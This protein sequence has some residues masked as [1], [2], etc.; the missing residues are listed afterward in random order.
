MDKFV[1]A[2]ASPQ[3]SIEMEV[4]VMRAMLRRVVKR[5]GEEDPIQPLP[6]DSEPGERYLRTAQTSTDKQ[7][8]DHPPGLPPDRGRL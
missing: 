8:A 2:S 1:V 7:A 3:R 4:A 5:I 6:R